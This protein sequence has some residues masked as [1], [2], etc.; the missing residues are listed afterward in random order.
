VRKVD[1]IWVIIGGVIL[2]LILENG[3]AIPFY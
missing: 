1:V 3:F 2:S